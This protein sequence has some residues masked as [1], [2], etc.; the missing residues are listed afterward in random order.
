[1][2]ERYLGENIKKLGF[3]YMRLPLKDGKFDSASVNEMVDT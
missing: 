3:G 1:M 2:A